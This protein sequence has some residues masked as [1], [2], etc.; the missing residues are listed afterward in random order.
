MFNEWPVDDIVGG[1]FC[2][3]DGDKICAVCPFMEFD[4]KIVRW[5]VTS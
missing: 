2:R 1:H 5:P 4:K 3:D